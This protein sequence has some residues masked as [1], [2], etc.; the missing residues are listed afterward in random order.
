MNKTKYFYID[1][2]VYDDYHTVEMGCVE[3]ELMPDDII[4]SCRKYDFQREFFATENERAERMVE[5]LS[6][7][8]QG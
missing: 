2:Y 8:E 3:A 5:I 4:S 6:I 7:F 1:T